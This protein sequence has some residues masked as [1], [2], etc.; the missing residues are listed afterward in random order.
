MKINFDE[1]IMRFDEL[2]GFEIIDAIINDFTNKWNITAEI[3]NDFGAW[4][5]AR[6]VQYALTIPKDEDSWFQD[7][8]SAIDPD[9][10][11]DPFLSSLMHEIGHI[12]TYKD[13]TDKDWKIWTRQIEKL[14]S[15]VTKNTTSEELHKINL[16]YFEIPLEKK[17]TVWAATYMRENAS[18]IA[19]FWQKLQPALLEFY[20]INN[21][22]LN[23]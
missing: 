22:E 2:K 7:S 6:E 15:K 13:I 17:A 1:K 11:C 8:F 19:D 9:I 16:Q 18:E 4:A 14:E 12:I 10:I 21:I 23:F 3:G 5:K 20:Q